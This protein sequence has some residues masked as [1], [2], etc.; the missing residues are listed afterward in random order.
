MNK[1]N[2]PSRT[3]KHLILS[4]STL[5][6]LAACG[7]SGSDSVLL[8]GAV[9]DGYIEGATVCLDINSNGACDAG[10][11]S[12]TSKAGGKYTLDITG[13]NTNGL[14]LL[15]DVPSTAKDSDDNGQ[16][17]AA[18][19]KSG[20]SMATMADTPAVITPLTT[21][22]VGSVRDENLTVAQAR[23]QVIA[24]LG[25]AASTD[26]HEDHIAKGNNAVKVAARLVAGQLQQL[27]TDLGSVVQT[28]PSPL[29]MPNSLS[30]VATGQ[31]IAYKMT[32]AKGQPINATAMIFKPKS[33]A[34]ADGWPLVVFGHGTVGVGQQCAPSVTMKATGQWDYANLVASLV[35][36]GMVVIAPDYEGL[37]SADMG[38]AA[39]HPYL[40]LRSAGQSMALAA[41][42][43]K[44][45]LNAELSGSWAAFGHS[46]GGHA[47]LAGAQ[48]A[49]T[50]KQ[51]A[52]GLA[53]KGALAVAPASNFLNTLNLF[54]TQSSNATPAAYPVAY[55][56]IGTVSGYTAYLVNGSASTA[57][58][59]AP[60]SVL[61][62]RMLDLYNTSVTSTC[63]EQFTQ[64]VT[65]DIY[66]YA[67]TAGA[68]PQNYP[69]VI[70]SAVNTPV[71]SSILAAYE[72]G[73]VTLPGKTLIIQGNAD[74]T[75]LPP[76]TTL[77]INTMKSKGSDVTLNA[78]DSTAT[79]PASH[80]GVLVLPAAQAAMGNFLAAL[81]GLVGGGGGSS[82]PAPAN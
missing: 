28:S 15:A 30:S 52:P 27:R 71:F 42:A 80:S 77:L 70:A 14:T 25:L 24:A 17:L 75:V 53:Y 35:L 36:Q 6:V 8:N 56:A 41:V 68:T 13:I 7:G 61:G 51:L 39:G 11:P 2:Q 32:G 60:S 23:T 73:Q 29:N 74:T 46:Q 44:K 4:A 62:S 20:Y 50:A 12:D 47:A 18:A 40:N 34:P 59:I 64:L 21:R 65:A 81:F 58:S 57:Y 69:G 38:V 78:Y 37:G 19:G 76:I 33:T 63:A 49:G 67:A 55:G 66:R 9:I 31:L 26:L 48:F 72:P 1:K 54:T 82:T 43:A 45:K 22:L 3:K 79:I 10:E 16:T 5:L